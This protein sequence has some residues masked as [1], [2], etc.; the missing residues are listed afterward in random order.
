MIVRENLPLEEKL[1]ILSAAA[2]YDVSCTSSGVNR[3]G[4]KGTLGNAAA[5]GIC[6]S[7]PRTDAVSPC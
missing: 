3:K 2:R 4:E 7:L 5:C 1:K 6:H